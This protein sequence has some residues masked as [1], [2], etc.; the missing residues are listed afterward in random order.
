M[1]LCHCIW[2]FSKPDI[3]E[4]IFSK[5]RSVGTIPPVLLIAEYGLSASVP[6][7]L[8]HVFAAL[9]LNAL[10]SFRGEESQRNI[11][12]ALSISQI[13]SAAELA[14]W[15]LVKEDT[16]IPVARQRDG[17]RE[18]TMLVKGKSFARH[19]GDLGVDSKV[20]SMLLGLKDAVVSSVTRLKGGLDSVRNMDVWVARLEYGT[21]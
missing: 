3:A 11:R 14:G 12:C 19:V 6:E 2:Y 8:P 17:W 7:A 9:A 1:I 10:E 4:V 13:T 5:A 15:R 18:V 20:K 21:T 16:V